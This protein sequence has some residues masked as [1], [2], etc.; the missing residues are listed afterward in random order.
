VAAWQSGNNAQPTIAGS[1]SQDTRRLRAARESF[2]CQS[3]S[4][5]IPAGT[6]A[7]AE[8]QADRCSIRPRLVSCL[9]PA[10]G[11][12]RAAADLAWRRRGRGALV[13]RRAL[14]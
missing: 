5:P 12:P 9:P 11:L 10:R 14:R 7:R 6:D 4:Q 3:G 2:P 8:G 13:R 1:R